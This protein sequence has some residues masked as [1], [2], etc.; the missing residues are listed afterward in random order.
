MQDCR[1]AGEMAASTLEE[2]Q[3]YRNQLDSELVKT[4]RLVGVLHGAWQGD[5]IPFY[6]IWFM[7]L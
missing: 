5:T 3:Q 1:R 6:H 4:E 2:Y 7:P